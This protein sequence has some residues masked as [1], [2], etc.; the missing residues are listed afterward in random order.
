MLSQKMQEALNEQVNAELYSAYLYLAMSAHCD[1]VNLHGFAHWLRLQYQEETGHALKIFDYIA[2]RGA[3]VHLKPIEGPPT[4][5]ESPQAVFEAVLKHEQHVTSLINKLVDLA[6]QE[7][8]HASNNFLQWFV[9][10]QVE[11]EATADDILQKIKLI[12]GAPGGLFM[13]DQELGQRPGAAA[14]GE[15][16]AG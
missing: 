16:A 12:A 9:A 4:E 5:W 7:S 3:T 1:A 6:I 13:L 2:E 14:A 8:D 15:E 11:E 10:E